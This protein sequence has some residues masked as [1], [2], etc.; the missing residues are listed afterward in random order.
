[1]MD[2]PENLEL[3]RVSAQSSARGVQTKLSEQ[4]RRVECACG[5]NTYTSL[6]YPRP[7]LRASLCSA[8]DRFAGQRMAT[9]KSKAF[10]A[11]QYGFAVGLPC[12]H[13]Q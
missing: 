11:R 10:K 9:A 13:G 6:A 2:R 8:R 5:S 4:K 12:I 1:M 7:F 3:T